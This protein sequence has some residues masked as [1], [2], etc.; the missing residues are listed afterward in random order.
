MADFFLESQNKIGFI[1]IKTRFQTMICRMTL[2]TR[3]QKIIKLIYRRSN[4]MMIMVK[5]QSM[6]ID[7]SIIHHQYRYLKTPFFCLKKIDDEKFD[8]NNELGT[9]T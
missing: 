1:L 2:P 7:R 5:I 4:L 9:T 6:N 8:D 3:T